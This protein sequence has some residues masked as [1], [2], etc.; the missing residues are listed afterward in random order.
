MG[1]LYSGRDVKKKRKKEMVRK[2]E[3]LERTNKD[4]EG[5]SVLEN[6]DTD[7]LVSS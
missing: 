4:G 2:S 6:Y 3:N 5:Q 1:Q 7:W